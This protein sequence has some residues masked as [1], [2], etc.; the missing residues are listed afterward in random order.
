MFVALGIDNALEFLRLIG[1]GRD[2][3]DEVRQQWAT[4]TVDEA[5]EELRRYG[6]A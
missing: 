1:G 4:L 3:F 6:L 5:L 2:R